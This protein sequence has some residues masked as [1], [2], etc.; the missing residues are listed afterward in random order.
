MALGL[1]DMC[2]LMAFGILKVVSQSQRKGAVHFG[3]ACLILE[4]YCEDWPKTRAV[5]QMRAQ[6]IWNHW[7]LDGILLR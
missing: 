5:L 3:L 6:D 4:L 1:T 7:G 2:N